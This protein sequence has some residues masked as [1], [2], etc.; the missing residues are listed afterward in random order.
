MPSSRIN[1]TGQNNPGQTSRAVGQT[2]NYGVSR[3]HSN[4]LHQG[5]VV[6]GEISDLRNN[7]ITITMENNMVLKGQIT[8]SS[9]LSI[10]Q[11]AAF[12]LNT[13]APSGIIMEAI[14]KSFSETELTLINKALQEA[15]LPATER[16]QS[17]VKAL[18]DN[19]LPINKQSIQHLMQL[20]YDYSTD[21]M[22]TLAI[23]NRSH[24]TI[25][26][27]SVTQFSNYRNDQYQL[28]NK[29]QVFAR[30]LPE[31]LDFLAD[32]GPANAVAD[33]GGKLLSI[34]LSGQNDNVQTALQTIS[35]LTV[36]QQEEIRQMLSDTPLTDEK[37]LALSNGSLTFRDAL[38]L[39][40]DAALSGSL[41]LSENVS[42]SALAAKMNEITMLLEPTTDSTQL[43]PA[44]SFHVTEAQNPEIASSSPDTEIEP[45]LSPTVPEEETQETAS[46]FTLAGKLF[47][48]L[49]DAAKSS[50]QNLNQMLTASTPSGQTP[51]IIDTILA[52]WKHTSYETEAISLHLS[53]QDR[54]QFLEQL[55][56]FPISQQLKAS[57]G[58]G[59]ASIKEIFTAIHDLIPLS[60]AGQVRDLF[61]S[62]AFQSLFSHTLLSS[63]TV[64]PK[65]LA[66]QN[67]MD[68]FYQIMEDKMN[69]FERLISTTLSGNDS[70]QLSGEAHDMKENINFMKLLNETFAYMQL[71][72]K[73]QNQ[74]AHGDLYVYTNKEKRKQNPEQ[75]S[76]L[77]HLDMEHL[78]MVDVKLEK[79]HNEV[80]ASFYLDNHSALQLLQNNTSMLENA[81]LEKG[82]ICTV[83]VESQDKPVTVNDFLNTKI[84]SN[85]SNEMKR[86]SFD[87]RA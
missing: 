59:E 74:N 12:R 24:M 83:H 62:P 49:S 20:A 51:D 46:R 75:I 73:L 37:L 19:L 85:T 11:T 36:E 16:N 33:F 31:L 1:P 15:G 21:D 53:S 52:T 70:S 41:K 9:H 86:F 40:R 4:Q 55:E 84:A 77:L 63:L 6:R 26:K 60:P 69:A 32:N 66:S 38:A 7:E 54:Q 57:I 25:T 47:Q 56:H 13:V 30:Q 29:I 3:P 8:D 82:Y 78:G 18:M 14:P 34:T 58:S 80:K 39:I 48:N 45:S 22:N 65:Q 64:T 72:L 28:L 61:Q 79:D 44:S 10:G 43:P 68:S 35:S 2:S 67:G 23:M 27:D 71:P 50:I 17:A 87:I 76:V 42:S 5:D 81:L